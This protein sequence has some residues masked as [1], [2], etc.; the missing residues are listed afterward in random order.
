MEEA[1][2]TALSK[3]HRSKNVARVGSDEKKETRG[4]LKS[5][6]KGR[7]KFAGLRRP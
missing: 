2:S 1:T 7:D 4:D 3:F 5:R 6:R